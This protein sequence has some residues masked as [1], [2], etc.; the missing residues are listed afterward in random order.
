MSTS[1]VLESR[2]LADIDHNEYPVEPFA[3]AQ[4]EILGEEHSYPMIAYG[5]LKASAAWK[6]YAKAQDVPFE[7][8]NA[9]SNRLKSYELAIK[10]SDDE[11]PEESIDISKYIGK[12]FESIYQKSKEYLGVISSWSIHPCSYL[13]YDGNI[14]EEIGIVKIKD[15]ICCLMDGHWAEAGHFLKQDHLAVSVVNEIFSAF[16]RIGKEPPTVSELLS[17]CT[18]DD[19]AWSIY[20]KGCWQ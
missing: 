6:L 11:N 8:A 3:R 16:K 14:K 13:I 19:A 1:R 9:I 18:P 17:M 20:E 12:E 15:H 2:T 5:T 7:T 4:K 10:H